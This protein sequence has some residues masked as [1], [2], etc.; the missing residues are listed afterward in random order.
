MTI[1]FTVISISFALSQPSSQEHEGRTS[2]KH[3]LT[4]DKQNAS[5]NPSLTIP[6]QYTADPYYKKANNAQ[7]VDNHPTWDWLLVI[8]NGLLVLFTALLFW[9]T[10]RMWKAT[11]KAADAAKASA[12]A[13]PIIEKAF[14]FI[15]NVEWKP[16]PDGA[17]FHAIGDNIME[18][19]LLNGGKTPAVLNR[20]LIAYTLREQYPT[21]EEV[22]KLDN[23]IPG[24]TV[25]RSGESKTG[26]IDITLTE[27]Q[28]AEM[29]RH[30]TKL[31]CYGRVEYTD[32][33]GKSHETGFCWECPNP[34]GSTFTISDNKDL[35]RYT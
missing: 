34:Q 29:A 2:P 20:T 22:G 35:N 28:W 15:T 27:N 7:N 13:L 23:I 19:S 30:R 5:N 6:Q 8:F 1:I 18:V 4:K 11:K 9:S 14:M 21:Q 16:K 26:S 17:K 31:L 10:H 25:I 33:F 3:E 12:E 32:I 24:N